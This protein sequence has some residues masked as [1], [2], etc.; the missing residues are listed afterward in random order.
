MKPRKHLFVSALLTLLLLSVLTGCG[1]Q[2][3]PVQVDAPL[4][5]GSLRWVGTCAVLCS[6][7]GGIC[8]VLASNRRK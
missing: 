1:E 4:L 6:T 8:L 3:K 7:I 2:D 5:A